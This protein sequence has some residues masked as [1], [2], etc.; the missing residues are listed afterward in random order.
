MEIPYIQDIVG[1]KKE[2]PVAPF[3]EA[4]EK[5]HCCICYQTI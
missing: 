5:K 1:D 2:T 3:A 4:R